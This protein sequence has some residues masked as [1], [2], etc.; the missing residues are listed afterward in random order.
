MS[1][2]LYSLYNNKLRKFGVS[3]SSRFRASF[4]EALNLTYMDLNS[5][6]FAASTM[7]PIDSFDDIIDERLSSFATITLDATAG[8]ADDAIEERD[9]WKAEYW[10]ERTS[11]TNGFTD[12]ITDDASNVVI[13]IANNVVS[14]TGS[15][16]ACS[17]ALS[18]ANTFKLTV[19]STEDGNAIYVDD[20]AVSLTYTTGDEDTV[21]NIGTITSH[22]FSGTSGLEL[23]RF[24]FLTESS[25]VYDFLMEEETVDTNLTDVVNGFTATI[26]T[27][28]WVERYV[29]PSSTLS[30]NW[31]SVLDKG[32]DYHLQDGGEWAIEPEDERERKWRDTGIKDGRR[33]QQ[34]ESTYTNPLGV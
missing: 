12:T 23:L 3:D 9:F 32:L 5:E 33:I 17:G 10:F 19:E 28:F 25:V 24:R 14:L 30:N 34:I 27:P 8:K 20:N 7:V 1:V 4:V 18:D 16:V 15:T 29:E 21:Q 6:V 31:R 22:V 13:A 2:N 11:D 26:A